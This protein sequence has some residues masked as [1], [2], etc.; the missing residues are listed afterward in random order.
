MDKPNLTSGLKILLSQ[1][2][3]ISH[4]NTINLSLEFGRPYYP[5]I[6][7]CHIFWS[8]GVHQPAPSMPSTEI[9]FPSR[10]H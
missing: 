5:L 10:E 8:L 9:V 1:S 3:S 4:Y 7:P 6:P 2:T